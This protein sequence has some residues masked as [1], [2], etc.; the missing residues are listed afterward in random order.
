MNGKNSHYAKLVI[1]NRH[2]IIF[3]SAL[4]LSILVIFFEYLNKFQVNLKNINF[5]VW[6]D[7]AVYFNNIL[8]PILM[9]ATIYL[10]YRTWVTSKEEL[11][12]T[13]EELELTRGIQEQPFLLDIFRSRLNSYYDGCSEEVGKIIISQC[14]MKILK[15]YNEDESFRKSVIK[16]ATKLG[17]HT[18]E[19]DYDMGWNYFQD[20]IISDPVFYTDVIS[21][22]TDERNQS[23]DSNINSE[24]GLR[25]YWYFV[26]ANELSI[27]YE[28]GNCKKSLFLFKKV[29]SIEKFI[30][31]QPTE[32][33]FLMR[34]ELSFTVPEEL[35]NPILDV[36]KK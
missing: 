31:Q 20:K 33:N 21:Y 27:N 29:S 36:I 35:Y 30:E 13:R 3:Y 5:K 6:V 23:F 2:A 26:I 32:L 34:D 8:S 12:A 18:G 10:V 28:Q 17:V 9:A 22:I 11:R 15:S 24:Q 19:D 14:K 16:E 4:I 7:V 25:K 1:N